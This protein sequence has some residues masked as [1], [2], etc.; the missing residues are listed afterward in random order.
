MGL[1]IPSKYFFHITRGK[2]YCLSIEPYLDPNNKLSLSLDL[3]N[4]ES[5]S[6]MFGS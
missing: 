2:S 3:D 1:A 5:S 6:D 4:R